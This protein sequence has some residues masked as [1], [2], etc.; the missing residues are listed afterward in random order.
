M[1]DGK[2]VDHRIQW[3]E[4]YRTCQFLVY[5]LLGI[6]LVFTFVGRVIVVNGSS[7]LPTLQHGDILLL[8]TIGYTPKQGD[9]VV[10][11]KA[12]FREGTPIVKR[13]IAMGGQ[14][15]DIDYTIP[16]VYVDG[17]ELDEPYLLEVMQALPDH[18]IT[19]TQVPE[20]SIFVM[21]D[22]RNGSADSRDPELGVVDER[23]VLGRA[24]FVM[25]PFQNAG[26]I[27]TVSG[28]APSDTV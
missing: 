2:R 27:E 11:S 14:T 8:Q 20:G 19:H 6:V 25:F 7:M 22:N 18:Y 1:P 24:F 21:G 9:V 16:A 12:S 28:P 5:L 23:R 15:V 13:V 4:S 26:I 17:V 3:A 10:L